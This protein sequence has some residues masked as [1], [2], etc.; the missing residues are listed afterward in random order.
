MLS[1][2]H[3]ASVH[4]I[5]VL[6]NNFVFQN[7]L[8]HTRWKIYSWCSFCSLFLSH[9]SCTHTEAV[10]CLRE[11]SKTT[12]VASFSLSDNFQCKDTAHPLTFVYGDLFRHVTVLKSPIHQGF[13]FTLTTCLSTSPNIPFIRG[14]IMVWFFLQT[15]LPHLAM[16]VDDFVTLWSY[17]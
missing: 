3:Y 1:S 7:Y 8:F 17:S 4:L 14:L 10:N 6:I 2:D 16:H 13:L 11:Q 15:L 5:V 12:S 9:S